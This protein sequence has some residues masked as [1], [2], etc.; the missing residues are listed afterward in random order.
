MGY[1]KR[2][3]EYKYRRTMKSVRISPDYVYENGVQQ[4]KGCSIV[5]TPDNDVDYEILELENVSD[6]IALRDAL[7]AFINSSVMENEDILRCSSK[8]SHGK[9]YLVDEKGKRYELLEIKEIQED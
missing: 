7:T 9:T 8:K 6:V 3:K 2:I 1:N 4:L 5:V